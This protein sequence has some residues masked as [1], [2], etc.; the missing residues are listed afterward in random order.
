MLSSSVWCSWGLHWVS[1]VL[2]KDSPLW[3]VLTWMGSENCSAYNSPVILCL[4]SW[5]SLYTYKTGYSTMYSRR[6]PADF[7]GSLSVDPFCFLPAALTVN[8]LGSKIE[9]LKNLEFPCCVSP[10][11]L[12]QTLHYWSSWWPNVWEIFPTPSSSA[13]PSRSYSLTQLWN[14]I[15]LETGSGLKKLPPPFSPGCQVCFWSIGY[16]SEVPTTLSSGSISLLQWH[17]EPRETLIY[18]NLFIKGCDFFFLS[19][20][21]DEETLGVRCG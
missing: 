11:L 9:Y 14:L 2:V 20:Q 13:T 5:S 19:R 6:I 10:L 1:R 12:T 16:K 18:T 17:T 3:L 8:F 15:Y 7:W 21:P 4:I